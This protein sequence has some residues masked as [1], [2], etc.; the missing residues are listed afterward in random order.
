M[1]ETNG[2]MHGGLDGQDETPGD[3]GNGVSLPGNQTEVEIA[4]RECAEF[5]SLMPER[6]GA[7]DD[8]QTYPHML[9][10]ERCRSLVRDLELIAEAARQLMPIEEEPG[11]ELWVKIQMAIESGE[12]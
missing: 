8:L 4:D 2:F 9:T 12:A 11:D 10:C 3:V 7:G 6:I 5:Q 1:T